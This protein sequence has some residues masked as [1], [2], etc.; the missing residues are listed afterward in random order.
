MKNI[1]IEHDGTCPTCRAGMYIEDDI[2]RCVFCELVEAERLN[3]LQGE[4]IEEQAQE[5]ARL[6]KIIANQK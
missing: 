6:R 3:W 1:E 2:M 5:I 4:K